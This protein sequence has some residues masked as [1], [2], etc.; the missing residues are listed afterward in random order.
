MNLFKI[1]FPKMVP[2]LTNCINGNFIK[3]ELFWNCKAL[4]QIMWQLQDSNQPIPDLG[5]FLSRT[6]GMINII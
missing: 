4:S 1:S 5:S 3:L 6:N 2:M